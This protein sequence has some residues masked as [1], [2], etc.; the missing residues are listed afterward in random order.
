MLF[1]E[2]LRE[3]EQYRQFVD[4]VGIPV[5]ANITEFGITPLHEVQELA[6]VGVSLV[7]YPLSAFRAMN[8]AAL[9]VYRAIRNDGTQK[10]VL[11]SMQTREEL[12]E[13]L[14]YYKYEQKLD[15][16]DSERIPRSLLRGLASESDENNSLR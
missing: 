12:Y 3:L 4:A 14:D 7:L 2:A 9:N 8:A 15:E 5:L 13:F 10:G 6:G 1:P 11:D 16:T